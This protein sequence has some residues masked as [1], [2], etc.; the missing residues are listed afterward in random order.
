MQ[1]H[2][3][4]RH[5]FDPDRE[6]PKPVADAPDV[7]GIRQPE[8]GS[9]TRQRQGR[10]QLIGCILELLPETMRLR[11]SI[12]GSRIRDLHHVRHR[13]GGAMCVLTLS[14]LQQPD[15][16]I[17]VQPGTI[18]MF[19]DH[20]EERTRRK[21]LQIRQDITVLG[22]PTISQLPPSHLE[23]EIILGGHRPVALPGKS[24][25]PTCCESNICSIVQHH[26][27]RFQEVR[28][29]SEQ[30]SHLLVDDV[31]LVVLDSVE[32]CPSRILR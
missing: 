18:G 6:A 9:T 25:T 17:P 15:H 16:V 11:I 5:R 14:R 20:R 12:A 32:D 4:L 24:P 21:R 26:P 28:S 13:L 10:T 30:I 23:G 22:N 8:L 31:E 19:H 1:R 2:E 7:R 29:G 3:P 27:D